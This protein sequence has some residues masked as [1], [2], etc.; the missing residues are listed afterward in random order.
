[1]CKYTVPPPVAEADEKDDVVVDAVVQVLGQ[2][3]P[4]T[5]V[6]ARARGRATDWRFNA[7]GAHVAL[8]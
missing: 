7:V 1:M 2:P 6:A 4:F 8:S 5:V 3:V